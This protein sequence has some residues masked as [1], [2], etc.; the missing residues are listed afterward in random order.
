MKPRPSGDAEAF[1]LVNGRLAGS[2]G[3]TLNL[4]TGR[5]TAILI[6]DG[7]IAKLGD[8]DTI[9]GLLG[10]RGSAIEVGGA[11]IVPGIVDAHMHAFDC[12]LASLHVSCLPPAVDS[13]TGLKRRLADRAGSRPRG[14]WVVATGYDD[15]RLRET[16]APVASRCRFSGSASPGGRRPCLRAYERGKHPRAR[17]RRN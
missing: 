6:E 1:A 16:A 12:A 3:T 4:S 10:G 9:R 17:I 14:A 11:V 2:Y 8:D 15:T 5:P 7:K 13:L